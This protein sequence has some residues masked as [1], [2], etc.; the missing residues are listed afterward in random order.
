MHSRISTLLLSNPAI[1]SSPLHVE[2][3]STRGVGLIGACAPPAVIENL[4]LGENC[5]L[6]GMSYVGL[7]GFTHGN[8]TVHF[9]NL[10]NNAYVQCTT[11]ANAGGIVGCNFSSE[12]TIIM[13]KCYSMATIVGVNENGATRW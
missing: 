4:T 11:G 5:R 13:N 1:Q 2:Q 10:G 9:T 8:G 3:P 7:I 12:C 6:I